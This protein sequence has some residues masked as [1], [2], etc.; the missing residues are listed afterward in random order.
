[1][2]QERRRIAGRYLTEIQNP[3]ITLP[4]VPEYAVPVWHIFGIRCRERDALERWLGEKGIGTGRHYPVPI[5]LQECY[6]ELGYHKGDFPAAEEISETQLSI[7]MY[8]GMTEEEITYVIDSINSF[9][10]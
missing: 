6:K 10:G 9:R 5:H 7:P 3:R 2:N 1:M 4:F 8:Y